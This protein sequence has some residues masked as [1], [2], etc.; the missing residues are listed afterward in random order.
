[1]GSG[2]PCDPVPEEVH[3]LPTDNDV[4]AIGGGF[5]NTWA[6]CKSGAA[7]C[8]GENQ[9]RQCGEGPNNLHVMTRVQELSGHHVVAVEGG[10]CHT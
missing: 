2:L 1:M 10:Y 6:T 8:A 5:Y 9:N 4:T 7:Y 3:G